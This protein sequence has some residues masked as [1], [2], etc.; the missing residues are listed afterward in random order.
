MI[1]RQ[2]NGKYEKVA[3]YIIL[4]S[5]YTIRVCETLPN[6]FHA[7][8]ELHMDSFLFTRKEVFVGCGRRHLH[9]HE[10]HEQLADKDDKIKMKEP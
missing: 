7:S 5:L 8:N 6:P 3:L 4:K 1:Q 2:I 10:Q 9:V